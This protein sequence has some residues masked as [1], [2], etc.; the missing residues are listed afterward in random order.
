MRP[1]QYEGAERRGRKVG[2]TKAEPS[3][4]LLPPPPP[5]A[6]ALALSG[7]RG[8]SG[9]GGTAAG[10]REHPRERDSRCALSNNIQI[11]SSNA[12]LVA[13]PTCFFKDNEFTDGRI[14]AEK[15]SSRLH[16]LRC[17]IVWARARLQ[18]VPLARALVAHFVVDPRRR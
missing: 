11:L 5:L 9:G 2:G 12:S 14:R 13:R 6:R 17:I 3:C 15:G 8:D 16:S 4:L 18:K 10:T 7:P 1:W